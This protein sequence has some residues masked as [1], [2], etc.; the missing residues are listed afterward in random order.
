[1][2]YRT[3]GMMENSTAGQRGAL[4]VGWMVV[5]MGVETAS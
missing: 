5:S 2:V 3:E 4:S 1:M